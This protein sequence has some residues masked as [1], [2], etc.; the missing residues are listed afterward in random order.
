MIADS[1]GSRRTAKRLAAPIELLVDFQ[2][3]QAM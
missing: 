1:N 3:M 2:A